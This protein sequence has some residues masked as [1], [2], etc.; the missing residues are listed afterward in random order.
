MGFKGLNITVPFKFEAIQYVAS[1]GGKIDSLAEKAGAIN[2]IIFNA[3]GSIEGLNTDGKG[4][5]T[6]IKDN[7][8]FS[9][10][11]K[12]I[13]ILGS[14]GA[15]W[16]IIYPFAEEFP[17]SFTISSRTIAKADEMGEAAK[18]ATNELRGKVDWL[19]KIYVKNFSE[20]GTEQYDIIINATSAG[21]TDSPLPLPNTIFSKNTLAYDMMYGRETPFMKQA[22][23]NGAIVSDG[24]GMLVEQAAEAFYKWRGVRPE[25]LPV[26]QMLRDK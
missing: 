9:L 10:K 8:G 1:E 21:L 25:T 12:K 13:L 2:T 17:E 15:A 5:V 3:D 14:G 19:T 18:K 6:D 23:G 24:L 4:L 11:K 16:G 20:L 26:M 7:L 22:R